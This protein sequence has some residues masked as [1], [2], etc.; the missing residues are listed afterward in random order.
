M[1]VDWQKAPDIQKRLTK[2]VKDLNLSY[3]KP[4]QIVAFRS[5]GSKARAYARIWSMPSIWQIALNIKPHYCIEVLSHRFDKM[6]KDQQTKTLIH[7][8]LHIPKTFSGALLPHSGRGRVKIDMP[9][10][11]KYFREYKRNQK[12]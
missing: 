7:E 9:T 2:L 4:G 6:S 3:I 12:L 10:V 1:K 8:L 5:F 11:N